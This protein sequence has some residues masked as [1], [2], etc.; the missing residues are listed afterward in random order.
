VKVKLSEDAVNTV[1]MWRY[2]FI[3]L[4]INPKKYERAISSFHDYPSTIFLEYDASLT[5]VGIILTQMTNDGTELDW[6]VIQ[7]VLH[8]GIH[9]QPRYQN[10]VEFIGI[11]LGILTI[12]KLGIRDV[13]I[14]IRGDNMSSLKWGLTE[15]YRSLSCRRAALVLT[16]ISIKYNIIITDQIH[17]AGVKNIRCDQLSRNNATPNSLGFHTDQ[18][19]TL[20]ILDQVTKFCNPTI[21]TTTEQQVSKMWNELRDL[22][23]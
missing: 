16:T 19:I 12:A 14:T 5:G 18:I 2:L 11:V 15:N 10:T 1:N 9:G 17:I 23:L 22:D 13:S 20:T 4:E 3:C 7:Q 21:D 6:K 8:Y